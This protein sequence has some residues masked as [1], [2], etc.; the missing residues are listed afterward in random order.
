MLHTAPLTRNLSYPVLVADIGGTNARFALI[1]DPNSATILCGQESTK[2]HATIQDAIRTAVLNAGHATPRSALL[3]I[4]APVS[5]DQIPLTNANW[6]I[7]PPALIEELGL[8]QV[9]IVNDFEAQGL[10]LPSL[11][12]GDLDQIGGGD[13]KANTTK[14]VL[15]PGTGLGAGALIHACGKWIPVPGEGGHVELGPLSDEEYRIWPF[16]ERLGGRIGAEQIICGAGLVR[17]ARAVLRA[18]NLDRSFENPSDV[19]GAADEGDEVAQKVMRLFCAA[20]GRVAG[21][22][23]ITNLA[24]GGVYLA[25][26]IAPKISHWLHGGEF[27]AAFEAKAPHEAIMRSIPTYIVKHSSPALAGLAAYTHAPESYLVDQTGR[28]WSRNLNDASVAS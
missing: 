20:L 3:A 21:D 26:G 13:A 22:F 17:L 28:S 27:R 14:F 19:P 8:E 5:G 1:E 7:E 12:S 6:V 15:G 16:I 18:D 10:A 11:T 4:A 9:A 25:G 2:A 24:G 23:A